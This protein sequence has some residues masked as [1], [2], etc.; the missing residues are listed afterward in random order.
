[1]KGIE[2][3][4]ATDN[5]I[6]VAGCSSNTVEGCVVHDSDNDGISDYD[7]VN[8]YKTDP[9]TADT[10]GDSFID[11]TEIELG[12]DP[13]NS[14]SEARILYASPKDSGVTREDILKIN[15]VVTLTNDN[16]APDTTSSETQSAKA[17]ISGKGLPNSFVSL[18]IFSTPI[19]V[20]VKTDDEGNWSYVFDKELEN[21]N[22]EIYVG[23]ADNAGRI[24]AKSSPF[25]FVKTAEAFTKAD[26]AEAPV[27]AMNSE[28]ELLGKNVILIIGSLIVVILGFILIFLGIYSSRKKG[29]DANV[30][31]PA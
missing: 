19:V 1:M 6:I 30:V 4:N 21:G 8:I 10:D 14:K 5:G 11:S 9:F 2:I 27:V 12:H 24:I 3:A 26:A 28:P 15:S 25:P 23:M 16:V 29:S 17:L 22:H 18:F 31:Y 7:E 20:T 13:H